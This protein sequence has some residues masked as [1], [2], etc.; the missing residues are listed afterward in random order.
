MKKRHRREMPEPVPATPEN[1]ARAIFG[2][3]TNTVR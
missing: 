1:V 3:S 2:D